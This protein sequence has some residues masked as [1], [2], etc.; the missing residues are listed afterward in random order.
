MDVMENR[1]GVIQSRTVEKAIAVHRKGIRK[2]TGRETRML[3]A[4]EVRIV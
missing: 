1:T 4:K 3:R 2:E